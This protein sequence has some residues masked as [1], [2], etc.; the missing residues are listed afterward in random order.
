MW[1]RV[2]WVAHRIFPKPFSLSNH[3]CSGLPQPCNSGQPSPKMSQD[4]PSIQLAHLSHLTWLVLPGASWTWTADSGQPLGHWIC[5]PMQELLRDPNWSKFQVNRFESIRNEIVW[6]PS[7]SWMAWPWTVISFPTSSL[8]RAPFAWVALGDKR[9][10]VFFKQEITLAWS[11]QGVNSAP[12]P[13]FCFCANHLMANLEAF[14]NR[15]HWLLHPTLLTVL[16][17]GFG[18]A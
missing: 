8:E 17:P 13:R 12:N 15:S 16:G 6:N 7:R 5:W 4:I 3:L 1:I 9:L 18:A 11:I 14:S 10:Q 2:L